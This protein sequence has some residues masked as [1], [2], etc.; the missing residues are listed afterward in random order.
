MSGVASTLDVRVERSSPEPTTAVLPTAMLVLYPSRDRS[1]DSLLPVGGRV[2]VEYQ[3]IW[4]ARSSVDGFGEA[5]AD[6]WTAAYLAHTGDK[7]DTVVV[8]PGNGFRYVFDLAGALGTKCA[9]GCPGSS[10]C[11]A[12]LS[13]VAGVGTAAAC[14]DFHDQA[15]STMTVAT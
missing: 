8:D 5:V 3:A 13:P 1:N 6:A 10:A 11:G 2:T 15:V 4:S 12:D 9:A 14:E 7:D